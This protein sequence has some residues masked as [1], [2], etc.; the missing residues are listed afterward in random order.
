MTNQITI[1][2]TETP[3]KKPDKNNLGFGIHF[4]DHMFLMDYKEGKGWHDARI[5]PYAPLELNPATS[6]LHYGQAV[7]EGMKAYKTKDG[8]ILLFRPFNNIERMNI[9]NDR[10]CMPGLDIDFVVD[11]FKNSSWHFFRQDRKA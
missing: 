7:F 10:I 11:A 2:K 1:Q 8:R 3:K 5:V 6:V 9:S 4:T